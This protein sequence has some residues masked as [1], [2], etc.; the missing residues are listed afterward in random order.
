MKWV[1][2]SFIFLIYKNLSGLCS[3]TAIYEA[4]YLDNNTGARFKKAQTAWPNHRTYYDY[5]SGYFE[6]SNHGENI[7]PEKVDGEEQFSLASLIYNR[8][9][10]IAKDKY[11]NDKEFLKRALIR[12]CRYYR[13]DSKYINSLKEKDFKGILYQLISDAKEADSTTPSIIVY[14]NRSPRPSSTKNHKDFFNFEIDKNE[15]KKWN[16]G[17]TLSES[18]ELLDTDQ[19]L[20]I[21]FYVL[22]NK[23]KNALESKTISEEERNQTIELIEKTIIF[24]KEDLDF[25]MTYLPQ[26]KSKRIIPLEEELCIGDSDNLPIFIG[27]LYLAMAD[28]LSERVKSDEI[29]HIRYMQARAYYRDAEELF[30]RAELLETEYFISRGR[31][32][33]SL[34]SKER[35]SR[36]Y[37]RHAVLYCRLIDL[38]YTLSLWKDSCADYLRSCQELLD[39]SRKFPN[40]NIQTY[41]EIVQL[42]KNLSE[43]IE[44]SKESSYEWPE[45]VSIQKLKADSNFSPSVK[46]ICSADFDSVISKDYLKS[47][48]IELSILQII[49]AG[50]I[51]L[52]HLNQ[53]ADNAAMFRL[54]H[55]PVF[56]TLCRTGTIA[57]SCYGN[58]RGANE[59]MLNNMNKSLHDYK[60]SSIDLLNDPNMGEDY[61]QELYQCLTGKISYSDLIRK[62]P[63]EFRERMDYV[64][65]GYRILE[66][67]F[68]SSSISAYHQNTN[69][70]F[71]KR[72]LTVRQA[73]S[74][75]EMIDLRCK[76]LREDDEVY[77]IDGRH[78]L[79]NFFEE[80]QKI[81]KEYHYDTRSRYQA[82]FQQKKYVAPSYHENFDKL[83]ELINYCYCASNASRSSD[84]FYNT[85]SDEM[86]RVHPKKFS[87]FADNT[88]GIVIKEAFNRYKRKMSDTNQVSNILALTDLY[89]I[90]ANVR[91]AKM[92]KINMDKIISNVEGCT[93]MQYIPS[94]TGDILPVD[95]NY[96]SLEK[97]VANVVVDNKN[98]IKEGY[99]KDGMEWNTTIDLKK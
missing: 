45:T 88:T 9:M 68:S 20:I 34:K 98:A 91:K 46:A 41:T 1:D 96:K 29:T 33:N 90:S 30:E 72:N 86:L 21:R 76:E 55:N 31:N 35:L 47:E 60:F 52:L 79:L 95:F 26:A 94:Q 65:D 51:P 69:I 19:D 80:Q 5:A 38:E 85:I 23:I 56:Q 89:E 3:D 64:Y 13:I 66:E 11:G 48:N 54:V 28:L 58:I 32:T 12:Y 40:T 87:D 4:L 67:L 99:E 16:E 6:D 92:E 50:N 73:R 62:I 44:K 97:N 53:I 42:L 74:L 43:K 75:P 24:I 8:F 17:F 82:L 84:Y 59:Y 27:D 36:A 70:R 25:F 63:A 71:P 15:Y 78:E 18:F 81:A 83:N 61:R 49:A 22:Q 93:G 57:L 37:L 7:F 2:S 10:D 77:P 14:E 39:K